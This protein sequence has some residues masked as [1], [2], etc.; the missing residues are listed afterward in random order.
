MARHF[1]VRLSI[2]QLLHDSARTLDAAH[3]YVRSAQI[4]VKYIL[5]RRHPDTV[6]ERFYGIVH[7]SLICVQ[8]SQVVDGI[9]S[10]G[11]TGVYQ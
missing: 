10:Q 8:D 6:A 11:G 3:F 2:E 7:L 9:G 5:I 4:Q 1:I